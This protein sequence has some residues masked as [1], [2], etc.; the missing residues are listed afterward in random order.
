MSPPEVRLWAVL[1]GRPGGF[2]FR[3]QHPLGAY[4]LDFY[5]HEAL[6]AIEVDGFAHGLGNRPD[7]DMRR[8]QWVA[9]QGVATLRIDAQELRNNLEG[10]LAHILEHCF[11]R[12]PPPPAAVP[13]PAS[14]RGG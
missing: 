13:L 1:R 12:T 3:R 14:P 10:V 8:D 4:I 9:K 2:K 5:C 11:E 6:L 7:H